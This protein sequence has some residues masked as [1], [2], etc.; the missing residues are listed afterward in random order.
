MAGSSIPINRLNRASVCYALVGSWNLSVSANNEYNM[1]HI[2]IVLWF[3]HSLNRQD[4]SFLSNGTMDCSSSIWVI[5]SQDAC[6]DACDPSSQSEAGGSSEI[7]TMVIPSVWGGWVSAL[8]ESV[9]LSG[10]D[11]PNNEP[12]GNLSVCHC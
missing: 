3:I 9:D 12:I 11:L 2:K 5:P 6:V 7:E 8:W 4:S 1:G 10:H